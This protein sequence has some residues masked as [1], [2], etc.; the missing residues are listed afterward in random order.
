MRKQVLGPCAIVRVQTWDGAALAPSAVEG[1]L[2]V[3][4][5][6]KTGAVASGRAEVICVGPT[7]W[8]V[9][10]SESDATEWSD[11]LAAA[12]AG[13]PFRATDVSDALARIEIEGLEIRDLLNKGCSLDLH[14]PPFP[15]GRSAR[16]RFASMPVIVRCTGTFTFELIVTRSYADFLAAWLEDA[17]LEFQVPA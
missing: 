13:T 3:D 2:G 11:R 17:E 16:T 14:P 5:P 12:L 9:Q 7:D 1:L 8:L 6:R 15:V 10:A 4:W